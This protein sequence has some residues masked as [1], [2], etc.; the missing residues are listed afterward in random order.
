MP[1]LRQD[2]AGNAGVLFVAGELGRRGLV[3]LPT[4]RNTE[5]VDLIVSEPLG[6]RS[7]AVQVKTKQDR[8]RAWLLTAKS[9]K[10]AK[11]TLFYVFVSLGLPGELP[12]FHVV[13]SKEVAATIRADH[14]A[15]HRR[16]GRGGQPHKDNPLRQFSDPKNLH[17]DKWGVLRLRMV[18]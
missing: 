13:P 2:V 12:E 16:P 7:V 6:G 5:G 17:R 8:S 4:V 3:A 11:P 1:R 10:L 9:E 15:W 14:R 18:P